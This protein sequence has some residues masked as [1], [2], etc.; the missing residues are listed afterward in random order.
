M[1]SNV[2]FDHCTLCGQPFAAPQAF[3]R[4]VNCAPGYPP[5]GSLAIRRPTTVI[6]HPTRPITYHLTPAGRAALRTP[7]YPTHP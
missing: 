3:G 5:A 6:T 7:H 4:C 1:S 2:L